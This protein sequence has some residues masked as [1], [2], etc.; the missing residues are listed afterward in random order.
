MRV[1]WGR[2]NPQV[3]F[4]PAIIFKITKLSQALFI[5]VISMRITIV[6]AVLVLWASVY[7]TSCDFA[8]ATSNVAL[9][10]DQSDIGSS[11]IHPASYLYFLK[12]IRENLEMKLAG[13]PKIKS[14][15]QLEFST[16]RIREVN[17]LSRA[18]SRDQKLIEP[19]ME[20]YWQHLKYLISNINTSDIAFLNE[21]KIAL[22]KHV[23]L[24]QTVYTRVDNKRAKMAI[25]LALFR[26][27]QWDSDMV[28]KLNKIYKPKL[29]ESFIPDKPLICIFLSK[30]A[31]GSG[32]N[33]VEKV[34][35]AERAEKCKQTVSK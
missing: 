6:L 2:K 20:K 21:V 16:R 7:L 1:L 34:T 27:S 23:A 26:L 17:S 3:R 32:L 5:I 33:D 15:R 24:L 10:N 29:T 8:L 18:K 4:I 19:T 31:S 35:L 30:E 9:T 25:R 13:T 14:V 12:T 22:S 28:A 11:K